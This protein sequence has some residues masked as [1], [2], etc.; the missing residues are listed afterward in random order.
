MKTTDKKFIMET[1]MLEISIQEKIDISDLFTRESVRK[2][3][4]WVV[5]QKS[6]KKVL[7]RKTFRKANFI[8][9]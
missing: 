7:Y 1:V 8:N 5:L 3:G 9:P 2:D 6:T 4:S